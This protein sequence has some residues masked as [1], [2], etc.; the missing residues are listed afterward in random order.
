ML[1]LCGCFSRHRGKRSSSAS[2]ETAPSKVT[3]RHGLSKVTHSAVVSRDLSRLS[4]DDFGVQTLDLPKRKTSNAL[5]TVKSKLIRHLS[6][7]KDPPQGLQTSPDNDKDEIARRAEL[8]RF[9]AQ[10]I[11]EELNEDHSKSVST[12]IS[13]RSTR[14][15][16][17]F[18]D[19]GH[20]GHGPRDAIEFS[21]DSSGH[22]PA[23]SPS[24]IQ[25]LSSFKIRSRNSSMKRWSSCPATI[26]EQSGLIATPLY[27]TSNAP[28][29]WKRHTAPGKISESKS[30]PNLL[31]PN[32]RVPQ[33]ARTKETIPGSDSH[34]TLDV[35]LALQE[36]L[37][38]GSPSLSVRDHR[39]P[40]PGF[41]RRQNTPVDNRLSEFSQDTV[42]IPYPVRQ[43]GTSQRRPSASRCAIQQRGSQGTTGS[44]SGSANRDR[45]GSLAIPF[46][47]KKNASSS[48]SQGRIVLPETPGGI[49][50]SYYPSVLPSVQPSPS[51]SNSPANVLSMQDLQSLELSPFECKYF[52]IAKSVS[53]R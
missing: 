6:Y 2:I 10:R 14:Y 22:L 15:L 47:G 27:T 17:P 24:P 29:S 49:S 19:I 9:R 26:G 53:D 18:I 4:L 21:I 50:S 5:E 20:P 31:Q 43:S 33:L 36:S 23:P 44:K 46:G 25:S 32:M 37:P 45:Q 28:P 8:R 51:R 39:L 1:S 7:D 41:H 48:S 11:Q 35:W 52:L 30:L 40:S 12:H 3:A 13:I 34:A 38:R 16:T 42:T